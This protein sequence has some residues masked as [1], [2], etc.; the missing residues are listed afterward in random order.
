MTHDNEDYLNANVLYFLLEH[1]EYIPEDWKPKENDPKE[2]Y[3]WGTIYGNADR[4]MFVLC[5]QY[6][7]GKWMKGHKKL[8]SMWCSECKAAVSVQYNP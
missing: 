5:L 2:I 7:D 4:D 6:I 3:F 8:E 1:P